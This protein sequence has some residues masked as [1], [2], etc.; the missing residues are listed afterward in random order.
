M[1]K[2]GSN[3]LLGAAV[4]RC[5]RNQFSEGRNPWHRDGP[6]SRHA[7]GKD[8]V[9]GGK[10]TW[11]TSAATI[12]LFQNGG[13]RCLRVR[14]DEHFIDRPQG[15]SD[16]IGRVDRDPASLSISDAVD[17]FRG[18]NLGHDEESKANIDFSIDR[19]CTACSR[20]GRG[21]DRCN[22]GRSGGCG[23]VRDWKTRHSPRP[24]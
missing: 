9:R 1:I 15:F 8:H 17:S 12:L 14:A 20:D 5:C 19:F 13:H 18:Y 3:F 6:C 10:V 7:G 21:G 16:V 22:R 11:I 4:V 2:I 23:R 24:H